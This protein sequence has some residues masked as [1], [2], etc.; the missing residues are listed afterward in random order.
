M[1]SLKKSEF[2]NY[3]ACKPEAANYKKVPDFSDLLCHVRTSLIWIL[4]GRIKTVQAYVYR[5][6]KGSTLVLPGLQ[7]RQKS[8]VE[9]LKTFDLV[10]AMST[11]ATC[12][13]SFAFKMGRHLLFDENDLRLEETVVS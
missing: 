5:Q 12:G 7:S 13:A 2:P 1:V 8:L 4:R 6:L 3:Y 10:L 11:R 9:S